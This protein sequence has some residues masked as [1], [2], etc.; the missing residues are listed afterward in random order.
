MSPCFGFKALSVDFRIHF[1]HSVA[2]SQFY[3]KSDNNTKRAAMSKM[4]L[5]AGA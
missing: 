4:F 1:L 5:R 3:E 2:S